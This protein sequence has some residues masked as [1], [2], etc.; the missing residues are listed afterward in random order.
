MSYDEHIFWF[1]LV[2]FCDQDIAQVERF[3]GLDGEFFAE[4]RA[5][6]SA[7]R[8]AVDDA[9]RR[10]RDQRGE[11]DPAIRGGHWVFLVVNRVDV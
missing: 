7:R 3:A 5:V 11:N 2:R 9:I 10:A 6:W 1:I 4:L 8:G